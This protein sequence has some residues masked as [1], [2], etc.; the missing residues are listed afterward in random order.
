MPINEERDRSPFLNFIGD[1]YY[2]LVT[3][4]MERICRPRVEEILFM[5]KLDYFLNSHYLIGM[6]LLYLLHKIR[7]YFSLLFRVNNN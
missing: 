1:F 5:I 7:I 2:V 4:G 6:F 3:N